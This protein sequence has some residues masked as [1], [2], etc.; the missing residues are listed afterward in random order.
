MRGLPGPR[1][2]L[3]FAPAQVKKRSADWG[4]SP[5]TAEAD[6]HVSVYRLDAD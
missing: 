4:G 3:F 2:V 1:P 6:T 5:F